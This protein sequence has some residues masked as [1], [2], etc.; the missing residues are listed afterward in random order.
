MKFTRI[1]PDIQKRLLNEIALFGPILEIVA[2]I[3]AAGGRA[4]LVGGAVRD[5][6]LGLNIKDLDIEVHGC[7]PAQ[8]ESLLRKFGYVDLVGKAFGVYRVQGI[9]TDFSLPRKDESGR[10]P[11]VVIDPHMELKEAFARR[12][13]TINAMGIDLRSFELVDPFDGQS[14]LAARVLR[15]PDIRFFTEDPLRFYRVMQFIGRFE[16]FPDDEL[17]RVCT[18]MDITQIS[19]E[20]IEAEFEKLFLKAKRPSLGIRW[21]LEIGRLAV[22]L[23]ELYACV[24]IPQNPEWHPEGNVFEHTMQAIDAAAQLAYANDEDTLI[25]LYAALCHDLGKVITTRG[26]GNQITSYGHEVDGVPL[27]QAMLARITGKKDLIKWVAL[28]VRHHMAPGLFVLGGAKAPA[29][30]RLARKLAPRLNLQMLAQLAFADRRGRNGKSSEPL[31]TDQPDIAEFLVHAQE[32]KVMYEM[33]APILMGRDLLG[34]IPPGPAMGKLLENAYEIQ[35]EENVR[36]KEELKRRVLDSNLAR[37][38]SRE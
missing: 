38:A 14:D 15:A 36:D 37:K 20:R 11:E 24:A 22:I 26:N 29:Y 28:M 31:Q 5:L 10:K 17:N 12:D 1:N 9:D 35:I 27:A 6:L 16:M 4:F 2:A 13:L 30:K 18:T 23:P 7:M 21:L 8:L 3:D 33:E 32:A 19:T 25:I 34:I